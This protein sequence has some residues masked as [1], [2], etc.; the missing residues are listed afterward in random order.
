MNSKA[1]RELFLLLLWKWCKKMILSNI[2]SSWVRFVTPVE[3]LRG[4]VAIC[5]CYS[6]QLFMVINMIYHQ[7]RHKKIPSDYFSL[8]KTW[9]TL[10]LLKRLWSV[11]F[12]RLP[13]WPWK[14]GISNLSLELYSRMNPI[15]MGTSQ[16]RVMYQPNIYGGW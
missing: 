12:F 4:F 2:D 10:V 1:I 8:F 14:V 7:T 13:S 6:Y 9:R 16:Q 3:L 15:Y 11:L 5:K